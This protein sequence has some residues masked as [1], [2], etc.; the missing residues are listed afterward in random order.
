M[1]KDFIVSTSENDLDIFNPVVLHDTVILVVVY[2]WCIITLP[3]CI[4]MAVLISAT[5]SN[6]LAARTS[7]KKAG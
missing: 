5:G 4:S 1:T 6:W 7:V 3:A 2:M